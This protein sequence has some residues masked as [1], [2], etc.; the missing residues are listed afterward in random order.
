VSRLSDSE[1]TVAEQRAAA[2]LLPGVVIEEEAP[3]EFEDELPWQSKRAA[4][5]P[6]VETLQRR[7]GVSP[8]GIV[9]PA[10]LKASGGDIFIVTNMTTHRVVI[11][12]SLMVMPAGTLVIGASKLEFNQWIRDFVKRGILRVLSVYKQPAYEL[13]FTDAD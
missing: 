8:D 5:D 1:S 2:I 9:G 6:G 7:L 10:T 3:S 12:S 4:P 11:S 13:V